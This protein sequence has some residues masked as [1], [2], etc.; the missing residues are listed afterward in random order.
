MI[1]E[2]VFAVNPFANCLYC[3]T[4]ERYSFDGCVEEEAT[5]RMWREQLV[6]ELNTTD[7]VADM[8][9]VESVPLVN[10]SIFRAAPSG[11]VHADVRYSMHIDTDDTD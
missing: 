3:E 6:P 4:P 7:T 9:E 10:G 11:D 2:L 5:V 1:W 8:S